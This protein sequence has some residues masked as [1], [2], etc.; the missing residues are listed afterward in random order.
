MTEEL[1][2]R[3]N[4]LARKSREEGLTE[5]ETREQAALRQQYIR[6]FRQGVENTLG[7]VYIVD[8]DGNK[9]RVEKKKR[10]MQ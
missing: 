2:Q 3:I 9:K 8:K 4:F 5:E 1:L 6:E 10:G 7:N